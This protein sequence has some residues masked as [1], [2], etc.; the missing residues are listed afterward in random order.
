MSN[1]NIQFVR[2]GWLN[3]QSVRSEI[4]R[5]RRELDVRHVSKRQ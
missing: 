2:H 3:T 5:S 1:V 4:N